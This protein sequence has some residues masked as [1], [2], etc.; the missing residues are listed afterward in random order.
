LSGAGVDGGGDDD[1]PAVATH[2]DAGGDAV[3]G[4][5]LVAHDDPG[6]D[7]EQDVGAAG[8]G[9]RAPRVRERAVFG[10]EVGERIPAVGVGVVGV[11]VE[12]HQ[13]DAV[14]L[15]PHDEPDAVT[16]V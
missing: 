15:W 3:A 9:E 4:R 12:R 5:L 2:V 7:G 16:A 1:L 14:G 6:G 8:A 13:V 11:D 10:F